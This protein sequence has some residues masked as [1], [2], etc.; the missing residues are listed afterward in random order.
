MKIGKSTFALAAATAVALFLLW[1]MNWGSYLRVGALA[2]CTTII[3]IAAL[4]LLKR[5]YQ[6]AGE[7]F[8]ALLHFC[9][10]GALAGLSFFWTYKLVTAIVVTLTALH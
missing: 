5:T 2:A 10:Y 4:V 3:G 1:G 6:E 8:S 9:A 7:I